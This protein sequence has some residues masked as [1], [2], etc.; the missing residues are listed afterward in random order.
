M[1]QKQIKLDDY[2]LKRTE[3]YVH[4]NNFTGHSK[5]LYKI[6]VN[7][8]GHVTSAESVTSND[9]LGNDYYNYFLTSSNYT[10]TLNSSITIT[11][12]VKN[13]YGDTVPNKAI[14]L[15]QN[16]VAIGNN[17]TTNNNGVATWT[18]TCSTAGIQKFS[19]QD[20]TIEIFVDTTSKSGHTHTT[21]D[22]TNLPTIPTKTSDLTNDS[23]FLTSHQD[24]S[25][26]ANIA[27][28]ADVATTGS[29]N[30]LEDKP[31]IPSAYTHP[32]THSSSMITDNN[33]HSNIGNTTN[34]LENIITN[35]DTKLGSIG[36]IDL[37]EVT[38][39][40]GTAS[41]STMNK[42]YLIA[43]SSSANNDNYEIFVTVRTGTSGNYSY[44][45]EKVD[46]ARIDLSDYLT[47]TNAQQTYV[48]KESGKGLF[49]GS[50]N[51]LTSKPTIPSASSTVPSA[52]TTNGA[53]GS[54]TTYA[55]ANHQHPKS[56]LYAEASHI[57]STSDITSLQTSL[58]D[59]IEESDLLDLIYPIGSIYM[60][61]D[62]T[63]H[64]VCP[65]QTRLGGTWTRIEN[66]FLYA[67]ENGQGVGLPGGYETVTLTAA[68]SGVPA[69]SH[70]MAHTHSHNHKAVGYINNSLASGNAGRNIA[71]YTGSGLSGTL[72]TDT[73]AT[74]SSKS[75]TDNNTAQDASEAH[76]NMPPYI[77]VNVWERIK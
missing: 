14:Q 77:I 23:N 24:I 57:H 73:D 35:I 64:S 44:D 3:Q 29:Y 10:P 30:D 32:T 59:K 5:G 60:E 41:A 15:Y 40:L 53:Y 4:P 25:G 12:T 50:Y 26:K 13:I 9:I 71:G 66:R 8:N 47:T 18:I 54:G 42:L 51:D 34:T 62:T 70:G 19:I 21:S 49:S 74:A 52:D 69:H 38:S 1:T 55:R 61:K 46:T 76:S 63:S 27:D 22:I 39:S 7:T 20:T 31:T 72:S 6:A 67:S 37:I 28:L 17:A 16:D 65:I 56:S 45:W 68:Q 58:D 75:T 48:A 43:E 2:F 33:V 36:N 11:C